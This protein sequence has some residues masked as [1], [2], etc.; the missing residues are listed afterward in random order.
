MKS[1]YSSDTFHNTGVIRVPHG[2]LPKN[3]YIK[4]NSNNIV[5]RYRE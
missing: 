5:S 2:Y 4:L 1:V 3:A